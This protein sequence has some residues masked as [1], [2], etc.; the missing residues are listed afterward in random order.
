[1]ENKIAAA[2]NNVTA[3][4]EEE[5][6]ME[7]KI[8]IAVIAESVSAGNVNALKKSICDYLAEQNVNTADIIV[9]GEKS[10]VAMVGANLKDMPVR[11]I[12]CNQVAGEVFDY[13]HNGPKFCGWAIDHADIVMTAG[14]GKFVAM[15]ASAAFKA[16]KSCY[17]HADKVL[18]NIC[19]NQYEKKAIVRSEIQTVNSPA[20]VNTKEE[21]KMEKKT[22]VTPQAEQ[23]K[24]PV[25]VNGV[26]NGA[27]SKVGAAA[28]T[29]DAG[30]KEAAESLKK[31]QEELAKIEAAKKVAEANCAKAMELL[32]ARKRTAAV[33]RDKQNRKLAV[34][35]KALAECQAID[36]EDDEAEVPQQAPVVEEKKEEVKEEPVA[37]EYKSIAQEVAEEL[38]A[39]VD[40]TGDIINFRGKNYEVMVNDFEPLCPEDIE[41]AINNGDIRPVGKSH[42]AM[43]ELLNDIVSQPVVEPTEEPV[44][45]NAPALAITM[46]DEEEA[47]AKEP[48]TVVVSGVEV[49]SRARVIGNGKFELGGHV[50]QVTTDEVPV[51]EVV[52]ALNEVT[53]DA[54]DA[55]VGEMKGAG[56]VALVA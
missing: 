53:D 48:E 43:T 10:A 1:M 7:K 19:K 51:G 40:T 28:D 38:A 45:N 8:V 47:P 50:Y 11:L 9:A 34:L 20:V 16:N 54:A 26:L 18:Q 42:N 14:K 15:S 32:Q 55:M 2:I 41:D 25:N 22:I 33:L 17:R 44:E 21:V 29:C 12:G 49:A 46:E 39:P 31:A 3:K 4:A 37:Q 35:R 36:A 52:E 30:I 56:H 6:K 24:K 5:I 13:V 23:P 27:L